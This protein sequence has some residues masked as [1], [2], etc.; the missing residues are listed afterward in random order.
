MLKEREL[1]LSKHWHEESNGQ[2][3][4]MELIR[5][6]R[7]Y[8]WICTLGHSWY[9][10]GA[11]ITETNG[12]PYCANRKILKGYNDLST[13]HSHLLSSWDY[14]SNEA[15]PEEIFGGSRAPRFWS[16]ETCSGKWKVSPYARAQGN[17]CPYC[18]NKKI[19]V[20]FN[21]LGSR[22]LELSSQWDYSLND[23][24][25]QQVIF[26]SH[27]KFYWCC[28]KGHGWRASLKHRVNGT[29]CPRCALESKSSREEAELI[30]FVKLLLGTRHD[31]IVNDRSLLSGQELDI[32]I[33]N[34]RRAL[35]FN[36]DYWHS[37]AVIRGKGG[38][39]A[40]EYH[41]NKF[42]KAK[43]A[44][45]VLGFVWQRDWRKNRKLT[46]TAVENFVLYGRHEPLLKQFS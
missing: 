13:T 21:D 34:L 27:A 10:T 31:I 41:L 23:K 22:S 24:T 3:F 32:Y 36:G 44:G 1:L 38:S 17:G 37:D 43:K 18:S 8:W 15:S 46:E 42:R 33:P 16:C 25:P 30:N 12:C 9:A 5:G 7:K 19:L 35:E 29:G 39:S 4:T 2:R 28:P 20:G 11:R 6:R 45:V 14:E 40:E 26:G